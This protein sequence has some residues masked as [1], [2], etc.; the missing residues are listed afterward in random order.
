[1]A[2]EL[3]LG[4]TLNTVET[5]IYA[6]GMTVWEVYARAD[7]YGGEDGGTV[8]AAVADLNRAEEK[9]P[10]IPKDC[11]AE[12]ASIIRACWQNTSSQRPARVR[13]CWR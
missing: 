3:I 10:V 12:V 2:P 1:M 5:D 6:F 13:G 4:T 8:I 9:R 7:P 11:P